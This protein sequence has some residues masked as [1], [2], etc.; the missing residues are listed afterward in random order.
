MDKS[1]GQ[2]AFEA[3]ADSKGGVTWD[4]KPIP[5]WEETGKD[6]QAAWE[7]AALAVVEALKPPEKPY[8]GD[9]KITAYAIIKPEQAPK[10]SKEALEAKL[11]EAGLTGV[12]VNLQR[13]DSNGYAF[14]ISADGNKEN[15]AIM[16]K[17]FGE[18]NLHGDKRPEEQ[19]RG[20]MWPVAG[21]P[22]G[23]FAREHAPK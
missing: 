7:A 19:A 23:R 14:S 10:G 8:E 6:V 1:L 11:I 22:Q 17:M 20:A 5:P 12:E 18:E 13:V 3:Y 16:A 9:A 21:N 15:A 4:G 2:I